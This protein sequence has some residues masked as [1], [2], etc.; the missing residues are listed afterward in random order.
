MQR[1]DTH[2]PEVALAFRELRERVERM[3]DA[4]T[5]VIAHFQKKH[6]QL[7]VIADICSQVVDDEG[8]QKVRYQQRGI[9]EVL[10]VLRKRL[11]TEATQC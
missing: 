8:V 11:R 1:S 10:E 4:L 7:G 9:F 3:P 5:P 6:K 2:P